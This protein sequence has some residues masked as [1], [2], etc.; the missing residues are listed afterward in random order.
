MVDSTRLFV[1]MAFV[2]LI[3]LCGNYFIR[4]RVA[5]VD[6]ASISLYLGGELNTLNKKIDSLQLKIDALESRI[7][8]LE[9]QKR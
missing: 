1:L 7:L 3:I 8:S 9:P 6:S 2:T 5:S 4:T